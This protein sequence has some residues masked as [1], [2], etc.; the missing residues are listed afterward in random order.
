MVIFSGGH[1]VY[2]EQ[3]V[4]QGTPLGVTHINGFEHIDVGGNVKIFNGDS[5]ELWFNELQKLVF[6]KEKNMNLKNNAM[7]NKRK[8]FYYS[9]IAKKNIW[10][11]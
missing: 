8:D 5:K 7:S 9:N 2:Q 3:V 10:L 1:F 6:D 11:E 4:S